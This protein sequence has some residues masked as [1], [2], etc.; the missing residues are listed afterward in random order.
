[1][2]RELWTAVLR[3]VIFLPLV[4]LLAYFSIKVGASRGQM[5]TGSGN[6][7]LV[8]RIALGPKAGLCIVKVG[9]EYYLI[10]VSEQKVELLKELP[11]Y[12]EQE[13]P[14]LRGSWL[15]PPGGPGIKE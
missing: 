5:W 10:G 7:R 9:Q 4:L 8:E 2:E 6:L 14:K 3:I 13:K 1:M 15:K 11:H 12:V